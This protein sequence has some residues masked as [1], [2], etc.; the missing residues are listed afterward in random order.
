[1]TKSPFYIERE[2]NM[3]AKYNPQVGDKY[4]RWT[5][6]EINTINPN[7]T[8]INPPKMAKCQCECGTIRYKEY[9]DICSGR[10]LSCG[11]LRTEQVI[12]RNIKKGIIPIG[13]RFGH[14]VVIEDLGL[15]KQASRNKQA[16]WSKCKCDCGTIIEV[17][18]NNLKTGCTQS[19]GCIKSRG[20]TIIR[21]I[22]LENN[23]NFATQYT[24]NDF[25]GERGNK[26]KFDFAIFT[27]NNELYELIE[28]DGRQH[29]FGPDATWSQS[30][31]L[32]KI[33]ERDKIKNQYCINNNIKLI[34]I[35]YYNIG[36]INLQLLELENYNNL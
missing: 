24:F 34:R 25:I 7:C 13:T 33:Q 14:L 10:S 35:P 21:K 8:A 32:E 23:I 31:S 16:R 15:R 5:V 4:G 29:Y 11:C 19:C 30:E 22:L 36:K 18:N 20:E 6:L 12:E 3:M 27:K 1:M 26:Y 2:L 28:F 9:R 17:L